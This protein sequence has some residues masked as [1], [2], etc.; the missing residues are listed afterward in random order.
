VAS[1]TDQQSKLIGG[2]Q[3]INEAVA[4]GDA[5][6][7]LHQLRDPAL[8]LGAALLDS[9]MILEADAALLLSLLRELRAERA[10]QDGTELWLD[11][12]QVL[13][14]TFRLIAYLENLISGKN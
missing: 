2:L 14:R 8:G 12:V 4:A 13:Q 7:L 11:D 1:Q 10:A 3:A 9:G 6:G 5:N